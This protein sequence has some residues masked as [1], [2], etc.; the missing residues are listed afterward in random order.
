MEKWRLS[1]HNQ[2]LHI[3][4][5]LETKV[6]DAHESELLGSRKWLH[7]LET[8]GWIVD[9]CTVQCMRHR[10]TVIF[11]NS[12]WVRNTKSTIVTLL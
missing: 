9:N 12:S 10:T 4:Y 11:I 2:Q 1:Q 5:L 6:P 8:I 7:S 3:F